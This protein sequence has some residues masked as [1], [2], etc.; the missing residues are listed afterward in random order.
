[1]CFECGGLRILPCLSSQE[2]IA[3]IK[4]TNISVALQSLLGPFVLPLPPLLSSASVAIGWFAFSRA[5]C[6]TSSAVC[7]FF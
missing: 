4:V 1:M 3:I 7:T 6:A 2:T 5:S